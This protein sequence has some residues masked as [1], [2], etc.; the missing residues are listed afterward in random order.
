MDIAT[1]TSIALGQT[2]ATP[3]RIIPPPKLLTA[4]PSKDAGIGLGF[5]FN[6]GEY[7]IDTDSG[8]T[9]RYTA[10]QTDSSAL[11]PW[12]QF[13]ATNGVFY[14]VPGPANAGTLD[15]RVTAADRAGVTISASFLL[16][17]AYRGAFCW[18]T[19]QLTI[20]ETNGSACLQVWRLG[21]ATNAAS[22]AYATVDCTTDGTNDYAVTSGVLTFAPGQTNQTVA[23]QVFRDRLYESNEVF[24]VR[25]GLPST[26]AILCDPAVVT[27]TIQDE[28]FPPWVA[29]IEP[30][31]GAVISNSF[32]IIQVTF[33]EPVQPLDTNALS[34]AGSATAAGVQC[35]APYQS[36][37]YS[38]RFPIFGLLVGDLSVA[39]GAAPSGILDLPGNRLPPTNWTY[40]VQCPPEPPGA[41]QILA[42][43]PETIL[44]QWTNP[45]LPLN[46]R[47]YVE[48]KVGED[49]TV[50]ALVTNTTQYSDMYL[51]Q[52]QRYYYRLESVNAFGTTPGAEVS[53]LTPNPPSA[54]SNLTAAWASNNTVALTWYDSNQGGAETGFAIERQ[55]VSNSWVRIGTLPENQNKFTD[56]TASAGQVYFYRVQAWNQDGAS[57]W[58]TTALDP[59][60]WTSRNPTP[61]DSGPFSELTCVLAT[62]DGFLASGDK[63]LFLS[64]IYGKEWVSTAINGLRQYSVAGLAWGNRVFVAALTDGK[65]YVSPDGKNW[66]RTNTSALN[67]IGFYPALTSG[68]TFGNGQFIVVGNSGNIAASTNGDYWVACQSGVSTELLGVGWATNGFVAVGRF[69]T[70]LTSTN[71][72]NWTK[73]DSEIGRAHV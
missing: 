10:A 69:G 58:I 3:A 45:P 4:L 73:Q 41:V 35:G 47:Y 44:L 29:S 33:S 21:S 61:Q 53:A 25:L 31:P 5:R 54:P 1:W 43:G 2:R 12:L 51:R 48:R 62:A 40:T 15:L 18:E 37:N 65:V 56:V 72:F 36:G 9:L 28:E 6:S 55:G 14:G 7:F 71:G 19:N 26:N 59:N 32:A 16:S 50:L 57:A 13:D 24:E 23:L 38:W 63:G 17:I 8:D 70:I 64:S 66:T 49:W 60:E 46:A 68:V 67:D 39:L 22:V 34:L 52:G 30:A 27:V 20:A 42:T 11:P